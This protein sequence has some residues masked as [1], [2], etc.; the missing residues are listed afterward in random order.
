MNDLFGKIHI[1]P[2]FWLVL[3]L[4]IASGRFTEV[5][6]LFAVVFWHEIGHAAAAAYYKWR[7]TSVMLLPFGGVAKVEEYGN[8]P[9]AE[10]AAVILAG[11]IQHLF[12]AVLAISL[13]M[14]GLLAP[15]LFRRLM[16]Y[17]LTILLFNLL[18]VWPLDGG[19]LLFLLLSV[20]LPF[21]KAHAVM[22]LVSLGLLIICSAAVFFVI[23]YQL[24]LWLVFSFIL[25]SLRQ[26]WKQRGYLLIRFLLERYSRPSI[27]AGK[28]VVDYSV[29]GDE[30]VTGLFPLFYRTKKHSFHQEGVPEKNAEEQLVLQAYFKEK[31][32]SCTIGELFD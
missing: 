4:G 31:R 6:L 22:L 24:N 10:E 2:L 29:R 18:P 13:S 32:T 12:I 14:N 16:E 17:N 20:R 9:A 19:K 5:V 30:Q 7:I 3:G 25:F 1:H 11:P 21:K 15:D 26:E 27:T 28:P 23:P 8:R